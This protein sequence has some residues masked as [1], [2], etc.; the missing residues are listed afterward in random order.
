MLFRSAQ[1]A[2]EAIRPTDITLTPEKLRNFLDPQQLRLYT[3]IWRRFVASQMA[4]ANLERTTVEVDDE[5]TALVPKKRPAEVI[6]LRKDGKEF[7]LRTDVARG[8]PELPLTLDAFTRKFRDLMIYG[9]KTPETADMLC[10]HILEGRGTVRE[11]MNE[12]N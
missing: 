1:E 11:L 9:G 8:E 4:P 6:L 2:H 12:L 3:L 10:A 7:R 5:M